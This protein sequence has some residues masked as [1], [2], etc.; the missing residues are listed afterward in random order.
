MSERRLPIPKA[1]SRDRATPAP[2][3][4]STSSSSWVAEDREPVTI[5]AYDELWF[6]GR[7]QLP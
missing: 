3:R 5:T 7:P 2:R 1:I 4:V 6:Q